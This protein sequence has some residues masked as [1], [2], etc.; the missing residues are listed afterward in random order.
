MAEE[1]AA[2]FEGLVD[3]LVS[4][5]MGEAEARREARRRFGDVD[6]Y[7]LELEKM[8]HRRRRRMMTRMRWDAARTS[9]EFAWRSIVRRPWSALAVIATLALGIGANLTMFGVVDRLLL[10]AP[11]GI[12]RPAELRRLWVRRTTDGGVTESQSFTWAGYQDLSGL[13]GAAGVAAYASGVDLT[14]GEGAESRRIRADQVSGSYFPLLGSKAHLGRLLGPQDDTREALPVAVL[15][16]GFWTR[17]LG[18]DPSVLGRAIHI[19]VGRYE[20]VGVASPGFTGVELTPV[21]VWLP[22]VP[23]KLVEEGEAWMENRQWWWLRAVT[24]VS[25]SA[26]VP[27]LEAELTAAHRTGYAGLEGYD[28]DRS[29]VFTAP[30]LGARGPEPTREARVALWLG[31]VSLLVLVIAC[32]NVA[33]LFLARAERQRREIAVRVALGVGRGKLLGEVLTESL[34][35]ACA[36]AVAALAIIG[37]AGPALQALL[38]PEVLFGHYGSDLHLGLFAVGVALL[39]AILA[40]GIPA[41]LASRA[42]PSRGLRAHAAG[43]P[44]SSGVQRT[45]LVFQAALCTVLLVGAGLFLQS[46]RE[47]RGSD[48]GFDAERVA[49]VTFERGEESSLAS[50]ELY[51]R[52]ETALPRLP[53]VVSAARVATLPFSVSYAVR[54][55]VPGGDSLAGA[56][57]SGMPLLDAVGPGFFGTMG[58]EILE[59]RAFDAADFGD[60]AEPV[61]VISNSMAQ[62]LQLGDAVGRCVHMGGEGSPCL[63]VVGVAHDITWNE[64]GESPPTILWLPE[65]VGFNGADALTVRLTEAGN[66]GLPALRAELQRVFPSVRY[67]QVEMLSDPLASQLRSWSLGATVLTGFGLLAWLVAGL[68][69]YSLLAFDVEQKRREMGIRKALGA[70]YGRLIGDIAT[71]GVGLVSLGFALGAGAALA[72]AKSVDPLLFETSPRSPTAYAAAG[73]ALLAV[74]VAASMVPA[75]RAAQADPREAIRSE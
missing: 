35:L 55:F 44:G 7:R 4:R 42:D 70:R 13:E 54:V 51:L 17:T 58:I 39:T 37:W 19:G 34:L 66:R 75:H 9:V 30:L 67:V 63:R 1:L 16:H 33:N 25:S 14:M 12:D 72:V 18:A 11:P 31:G 29:E 49:V 10:S 61:A 26:K 68:G 73:A 60:G 41:W 53:E 21:D 27:A 69:L 64:V 32:A 28:A 36:G 20:V 71:R 74:A 62:R 59:G 15:S 52:A 5:G 22:L 6:R 3:I 50:S 38:L 56:P 40:G 45:L 48:L 43:G 24:R 2:H 46:L 65:G 57:A 8:G 47:A 23:S